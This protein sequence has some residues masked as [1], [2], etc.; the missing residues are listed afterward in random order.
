MNIII[1]NSFGLK[2]LLTPSLLFFAS[3]RIHHFRHKTTSIT[4]CTSYLNMQTA[5]LRTWTLFNF[6]SLNCEQILLDRVTGGELFDRIVEKGSY[7]EKDA[8]DLIKQVCT[9]NKYFISCSLNNFLSLYL[10]WKTFFYYLTNLGS[11]SG[12]L[13]AQRGSCS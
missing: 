11:V 13:Y 4:T 5:N 8:A 10:V 9:T 1:E 6:A 7:T 3:P 12:G 2:I